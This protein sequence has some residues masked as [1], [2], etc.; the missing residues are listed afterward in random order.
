[1][2]II[3]LLTILFLICVVSLDAR[4]Q[5]RFFKISYET[6][7]IST[8]NDSEEYGILDNF[9]SGCHKSIIRVHDYPYGKEFVMRWSRSLFKKKRDVRRRLTLTQLFENA[10]KMEQ[11]TPL[12]VMS[13]RGFLPGEKITFFLVT[14]DGYVKSEKMNFT[15]HPLIVRDRNN[16]AT[17]IAEL[18]SIIPTIYNVRFENFE[19]NE[20]LKFA[21][22]S[23]DTQVSDWVTFKT[24]FFVKYIPEIP[25]SKG[26]TA[27][28][29]VERSNGEEMLLP[30]IWGEA[31]IPH[32]KG[33][34]SVVNTNFGVLSS[35]EL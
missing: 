32:L 1:M 16:R 3:N 11:K 34:N 13:S 8:I 14:P 17:V 6:V 35:Y 30:V 31:I 28:V 25:N 19:I 29:S 4:E 27:I 26:G 7:C 18:E 2:K 21:G 20:R 10:E 5:A 23:G 33:E 15:P 12:I 22:I 9:D 24:G